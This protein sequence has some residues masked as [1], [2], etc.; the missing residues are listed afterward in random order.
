V[1]KLTGDTA[2]GTI[3]RADLDGTGVTP[4]FI[5]GANGPTAVVVDGAHIYWTNFDSN[6]IGRAD[7]DGTGINQSSSPEPVVRAG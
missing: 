3:G 6:T 7:L 4:N 1:K 2:A 5:T